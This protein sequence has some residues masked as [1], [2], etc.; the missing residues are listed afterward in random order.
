MLNSARSVQW[1]Q[2]PEQRFRTVLEVGSVGYPKLA[3][4]P[5]DVPHEFRRRFGGKPNHADFL[6]G[7]RANFP[8]DYVA[9]FR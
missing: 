6:E 3:A 7:Y 1:A 5:P 4:R 2:T 9:V 8:Q